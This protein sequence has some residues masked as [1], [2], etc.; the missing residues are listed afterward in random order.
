MD[1]MRIVANPMA[2]DTGQPGL[3]KGRETKSLAAHPGNKKDQG[4]TG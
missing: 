4:K 3:P 2:M 1:W